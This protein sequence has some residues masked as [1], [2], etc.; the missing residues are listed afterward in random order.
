MKQYH[1]DN[2]GGDPEMAKRITE[3]YQYY[4]KWWGH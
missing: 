3:E 1:P 2:D 4:K